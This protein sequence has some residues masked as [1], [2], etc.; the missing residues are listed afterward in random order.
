[1]KLRKVFW[2]EK[3]GHWKQCEGQ[4]VWEEL[5]DADEGKAKKKARDCFLKELHLLERGQEESQ[6]ERW[7]VIVVNLGERWW[8]T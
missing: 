8:Y 4:G 5:G 6:G 3:K 2:A 7:R 1:M